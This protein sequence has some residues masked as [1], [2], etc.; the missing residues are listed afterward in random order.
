MYRFRKLSLSRFEYISILPT[1]GTGICESRQPSNCEVLPK[2]GAFKGWSN[3]ADS[4]AET[5]PFATTWMDL[6]SIR[7]NEISQMEKAKDHMISLI[8]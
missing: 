8:M 7:L 2:V 5:L 6:K 1:V 4:K 3:S